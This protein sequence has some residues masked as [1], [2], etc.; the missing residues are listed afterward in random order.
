MY[1]FKDLF[2]KR[3][4]IPKNPG[5]ILEPPR[6]TDAILEQIFG[7]VSEFALK[8]KPSR[9]WRDDYPLHEIQSFGDCVSFSRT[10]CAETKANADGVVDEEGNQFNF[11]DLDLAVGSGTTQNGNSLGRVSDHGRKVGVVLEKYA[12]YTRDWDQRQ[13]VIN[14]IPATAK[15]YKLGDYAF[16]G[17]TGMGGEIATE[18]LINALDRS[19]VQIA[20]GLGNTYSSGQS[21]ISK[22]SS[23]IVYHAMELGYIDGEGK[24]YVLDHYNR[25]EV[26]LAPDYPVLSA[27]AFVDLPANWRGLN[28]PGQ[29]LHARLLGKLILRAE[30]HGELYR[31]L[32]DR[33]VKVEFNIT[34][35]PLWDLVHATAREKR[36]FVG[37]S[38][39]DFETLLGVVFGK[40]EEPKPLTAGEMMALIS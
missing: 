31:V 18:Y 3:L 25:R 10:N 33:L 23:Y 22:P 1:F 6:K 13:A 35:K 24:R 30:S 7:A 14:R 4:K 16:V 34:D 29:T 26:V 21:V 11:A 39:K 20:V 19:P 36:L 40:V 38:E 28:V 17:G 37:V 9:D 2:K 27:L 32:P 5:L 12:P 8:G 15:R